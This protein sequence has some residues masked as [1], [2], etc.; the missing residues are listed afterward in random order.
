MGAWG[1]GT[2]QND[3]ALDLLD[4]LVDGGDER[5]LREALDTAI[6]TAAEYLEASD[7]SS[8]LAAAEIV[9]ALRG[10]PAADLPDE[11]VEWAQG[12][13]AASDD[14]VDRARQAVA[15]VLGDSE[16]RDLWAETEELPMW[17]GSVEE[18]RERLR[19]SSPPDDVG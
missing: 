9:A 19:P 17:Q 2:F 14:L 7:A 15:A 10:R 8:A 16:L 1:H 11:A 18:L 13:P 3:D 4:D 12:R 5:M 6:S